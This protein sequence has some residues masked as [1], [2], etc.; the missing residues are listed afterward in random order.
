M[1]YS[2]NI[3]NRTIKYLSTTMTSGDYG[4]VASSWTSHGPIYA[5]VKWTKGTKAMREGQFD[6]YDTVMVRTRWRS[7]LTRDCRLEI[8]GKTYDID[9]FNASRTDDEIQITAHEIQ[10]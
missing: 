3:L 6:A 7:T 9:S 5:S 2:K 10:E 4:M 8:D 1:A